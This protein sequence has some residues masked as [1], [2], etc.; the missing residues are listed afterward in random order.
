LLNDRAFLVAPSTVYCPFPSRRQ[1]DAAGPAGE[2]PAVHRSA[3]PLPSS[4]AGVAASRAATLDPV[5]GIDPLDT[6]DR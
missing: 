1:R 4:A 2:T 3:G 6:P 5:T